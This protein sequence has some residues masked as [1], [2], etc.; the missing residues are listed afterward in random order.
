MTTY[1]AALDM[2]GFSIALTRLRPDWLRLWQAAATTPA[3]ATVHI[4]EA[5][6]TA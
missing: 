2:A 1:V 6:T 4:S 3:F 5:M